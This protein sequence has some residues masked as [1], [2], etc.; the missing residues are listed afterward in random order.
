MEDCKRKKLDL[1]IYR[2]DYTSDMTWTKFLSATNQD[3]E[4]ELNPIHRKA[5]EG[6]FEMTPRK[7]PTMRR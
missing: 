3:F 6:T 2:C 5:L 7:I 4:E 1:L